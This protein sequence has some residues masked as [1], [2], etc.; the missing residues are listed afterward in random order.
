MTW[1]S[2]VVLTAHGLVNHPTVM[3]S[4]IIYTA[5]IELD[6]NNAVQVFHGQGTYK[7]RYS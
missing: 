1:K 2:D 3:V 4:Y 6:V 7:A 5:V